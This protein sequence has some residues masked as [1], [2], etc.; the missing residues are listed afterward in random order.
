V[1][2]RV[3]CEI[4]IEARHLREKIEHNKRLR[5]GPFNPDKR[6]FQRGLE[7]L[8]TPAFPTRCLTAVPK[9]IGFSDINS[10]K[11][12]LPHKVLSLVLEDVS[13]IV[14]LPSQVRAGASP[15]PAVECVLLGLMMLYK[16]WDSITKEEF[17][18]FVNNDQN[19]CALKKIID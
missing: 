19:K 2:A 8:C 12:P 18:F 3:E 13:E 4:R 7:K 10:D 15:K 6:L 9:K 17:E 11:L 16:F 5:K 1:A 14:Q